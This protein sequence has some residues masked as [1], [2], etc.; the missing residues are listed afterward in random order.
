MSTAGKDL[1]VDD[2][3]AI[4]SNPHF[5]GNGRIKTQHFIGMS[6]WDQ[7]A[8]EFRLAL[9]ITGSIETAA[10]PYRLDGKTALVTGSGRGIGASIA[11]ELAHC[12]A[13][14][15]VNY[16]NSEVAAQKVVTEI[17]ALGS[18]AV[19]TKANVNNVSETVRMFE[20]A[21]HHLGKLDIVSSNAGVVSFGHLEEVTEVGV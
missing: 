2:F 1:S 6:K 14:V 5:L 10:A 15:V 11:I 19:A 3:V 8:D 12:G 18:D 20:E 21:I 17:K 7:I 13:K 4:A 9:L 16:S